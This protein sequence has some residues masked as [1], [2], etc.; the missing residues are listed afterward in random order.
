MAQ[1]TICQRCARAA[2]ERRAQQRGF[3]GEIYEGEGSY[4]LELE[5]DE[6]ADSELDEIVDSELYELADLEADGGGYASRGSPFELADENED[7][8]EYEDE[9][10]RA[11]RGRPRG[12]ASPRAGRPARPGGRPP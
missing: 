3:S 10:R 4:E 2:R 5:L 7:E 8:Y 1:Q 6:A 11:P 12:G 9:A